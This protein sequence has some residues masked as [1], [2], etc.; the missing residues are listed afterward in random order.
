MAGGTKEIYLPWK[1]FNDNQSPLFTV[2]EPALQ[3]AS[4]IHPAWHACN[5][6][7]KKLHGRNCYQILGPNLNDPVNLVICWT[8]GGKLIGGTTTAIKLARANNVPVVNLGTDKHDLDSIAKIMD[9][10]GSKKQ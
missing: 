7:A 8:P 9:L 1:N 2:S 10:V 4:T 3:L 6:A 5:Q